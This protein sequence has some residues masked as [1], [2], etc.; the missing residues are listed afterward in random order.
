MTVEDQDAAIG[1]LIREQREIQARRVA[2]SAEIGRFREAV[3]RAI[4]FGQGANAEKVAAELEPIRRYFS[5]EGY[6]GLIQESQETSSRLREIETLL[7][8][9][10][11]R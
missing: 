9:L 5:V 4:L 2:L 7:K 6:V 8:D 11:V 1:R 3:Q 10:G